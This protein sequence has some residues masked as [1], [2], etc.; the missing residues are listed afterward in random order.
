MLGIGLN[1][2]PNPAQ[3]DSAISLA[4]ISGVSKALLDRPESLIQSDLTARYH[5]LC[6]KDMSEALAGWSTRLAFRN[7][8]VT[9]V[10]GECHLRGTI[11]GLDPAGSLILATDRGSQILSS[12]E[13]TRGPRLV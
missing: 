8:L 11:E 13:L 7:Q 9:I 3:P 5:A 1:L 4:E 2:K 12:G 6:A 10:D